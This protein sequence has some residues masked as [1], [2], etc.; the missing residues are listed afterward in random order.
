MKSNS[1]LQNNTKVSDK[2]LMELIQ[3]G[4]DRA[5]GTLVERFQDRLL[6]FVGRIVIDRDTAEELIQETFMRVFSQK[7]SYTPDY[8]VSTWIYTIALNLARSE[9]RKRKLRKYLSLDF[10]KDELDAELP[11]RIDL[12]AESLAPIIEQAIAKLPE[13]YRTAFVLCDIERL[14]Y[15]QIAEVMRVPVGTVKSRIN[16]ARSMLRDKLKPYK[17]IYNELSRGIPQ[18]IGLY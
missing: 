10:I 8:A 3:A 13:D 1:E 18:T 12:R 16:R 7:N 11:G 9:L 14:P 4:D 15:Q 2:E 5:F 17:E 6:N